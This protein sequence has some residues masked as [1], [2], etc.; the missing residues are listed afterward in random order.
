[1]SSKT[2]TG[3]LTELLRAH[4]Q[5][6]EGALAGLLE[7]VYDDLRRQAR[8][9][10]RRRSAAGLDS[11]ALVHE[12]FLKLSAG[13]AGGWRDSGHFRAAFAQAMRH[14]LVD[15]AR[16]RLTGKRGA[17]QVDETLTE[18]LVCGAARAEELLAIDRALD[19]LRRLDERLARVVELR[20][21][22]GFT[23]AEAAEALEISERTVHRDWLRARGWLRRYLE[24]EGSEVALEGLP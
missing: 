16:R 10:L 17:G 2:D 13:G 6:Q 23:E 11:R 1:M 15:A 20:F 5:G 24:G 12:T 14:I 22:A 4:D 19:W 8:Y 3:T 9:K 7:R 21:F 18:A